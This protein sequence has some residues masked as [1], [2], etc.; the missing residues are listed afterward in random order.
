MKRSFREIKTEKG[1][2]M[3]GQSAD[4]TGRIVPWWEEWEEGEKCAYHE[5][6]EQIA[7][8]G[9][10][11]EPMRARQISWLVYLKLSW[12]I[13]EKSIKVFRSSYMRDKGRNATF[14]CTHSTSLFLLSF[15]M[16]RNGVFAGFETYTENLN[17][18]VA[19]AELAIRELPLTARVARVLP[20]MFDIAC[21]ECWGYNGSLSMYISTTLDSE[22]GYTVGT[23]EEVLKADHA[24]IVSSDVVLD[25]LTAKEVLDDTFGVD[26]GVNVSHPLADPWA[27]AI[28]AGQNTTVSWTDVKVDSLLTFLGPTQLP[29]THTA[30]VVEF[31]TRKV[32]EIM[33]PEATNSIL[34]TPS[35]A[36]EQELGSRFARIVLE[37]W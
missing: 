35:A 4:A 24:E 11:L 28:T 7:H 12:K 9:K 34:D 26:D 30:G 15:F 20:G 32:K 6:T 3:Q 5:S 29:L 8:P 13:M 1:A 18:A 21:K 36:V 27:A 22:G 2:E 10:Q 37:P 23:F 33:L 19:V 16:Q 17:R 25:S 14:Y 31:S